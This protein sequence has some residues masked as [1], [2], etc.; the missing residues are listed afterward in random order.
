MADVGAFRNRNLLGSSA[1]GQRVG[2]EKGGF[3]NKHECRADGHDDDNPVEEVPIYKS[4]EV[5]GGNET[6]DNKGEIG[7]RSGHLRAGDL[8]IER[9]NYKRN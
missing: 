9:Q 4:V 7:R 5:V 6:H 3:G 2:L 8:P 1:E